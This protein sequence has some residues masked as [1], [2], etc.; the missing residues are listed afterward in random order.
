MIGNIEIGDDG[1]AEA[2]DLNVCAVIRADGDGRID[3]VRDGQHDLMD[4]LCILLFE[5][6]ELSEPVGLRLDLRLDLFGL[7]KL[8]GVFLRLTHE[9]ADLLG[10]RVA[11]CAQIAC[12]GY[13]RPVLRIEVEKLIHEG[14]LCVLKLL[15]DVLFYCVGVF[16]YELNVEHF[17]YLPIIYF[18]FFSFSMSA[19]LSSAP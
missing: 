1:L 7:L 12:F 8:R 9:H 14:K 10:E 17:C 15:L 19:S 11:A 4:A 13:G 16:S 2:L 6:F 5:T 3:D 18:R